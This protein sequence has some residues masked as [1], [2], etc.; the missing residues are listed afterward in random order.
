MTSL[1]FNIT[2]CILILLV[3]IVRCLIVKYEPNLSKIVFFLQL[4]LS[5]FFFRSLF[6]MLW[7]MT[8]WVSVRNLPN[9]L[10]PVR[11]PCTYRQI[12]VVFTGH[13]LLQTKSDKFMVQSSGFLSRFLPIIYWFPWKWLNTNSLLKTYEL[14]FWPVDLMIFFLIEF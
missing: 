8:F 11:Q 12:K 14:P 1:A 2:F 13:R 10:D 6:L 9:L 5:I 3:K 4:V 7:R